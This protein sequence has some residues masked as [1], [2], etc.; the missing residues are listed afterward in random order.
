[1]E[2]SNFGAGLLNILTESLYDKPIVVFREYVQNSVDSFDKVQEIEDKNKLV[3]KIWIENNENLIFLDN[4]V[5]IDEAL[6]FK[7][8]KDNIG[9]SKKEK[10]KNKG[11]KGIG[12]FSG[13]P[14]CEKLIFINILDYK[15][16]RFQR[17]EL[18]GCKY[19][20][21][22]KQQGFSSLSYEELIK[23]IGTSYEELGEVESKEIVDF[24]KTGES[25]FNSRNTGFLV[26]LKQI[27]PILLETIIRENF[28]EELGWLLPV[29]FKK[30]L[31]ECDKRLLFENLKR[32]DGT[33]LSPINSYTIIYNKTEIL[34]PI[35]QS[36]LR[37]HFS[38][39]DLTYGIGLIS[40][41][42]KKFVIDKKNPFRG[43]KV[44]LDNM[45]L[46][47]E[48]ELITRLNDYDLIDSVYETIQST[49]GVGVIIYITDKRNI[50]ANAR[51]TFF[52]ITDNFS[53][54]FS[55]ILAEL[56]K[57]IFK[58]RYSLSKLRSAEGK[59][60]AD[61]T[62]L[63]KLREDALLNLKN[64]TKDKLELD[65]VNPKD[66]S[67][68]DE[69]EQRKVISSII[70]KNLNSLQREYLDSL[71]EYNKDSAFKDFMTWLKGSN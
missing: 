66:F 60:E 64:L 28:K 9:K 2:A 41:D 20:K 33:G 7:E 12:R 14:Y 56:V 61:E 69:I 1:M 5:G 29:N 3:S 24:I 55:K 71:S 51:R 25:L 40:F 47:D 44:Y 19:I 53:Q 57:Y 54:E 68:M 58:T 50:S 52:E 30:E 17:F 21:L 22:K 23:E 13:L 45:L 34:R 70:T 31:Y 38:K 16:K 49:L 8:I 11:Y 63:K 35:R 62:K 4:G 46:C 37:S 15:G 43:I 67:D 27:T 39:L 32:P 10:T 59:Q 48:R 65:E 26:V 6:F 18:D 36:D 42:T